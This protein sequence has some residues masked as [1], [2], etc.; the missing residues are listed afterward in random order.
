MDT[1]AVTQAKATA[2][3]AA[4][5]A[6]RVVDAAQAAYGR[7]VADLVA[8]HGATAVAREL[9]VTRARVYQLMAKADRAQATA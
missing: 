3:H 1:T 9:G 2:E 8:E 4:E 5:E 7:A 6:A